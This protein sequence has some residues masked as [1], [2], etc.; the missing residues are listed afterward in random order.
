MCASG[1]SRRDDDWRKEARADFAL[2]A[3]DSAPQLIA[4]FNSFCFNVLYIMVARILFSLDSINLL[5]TLKKIGEYC[6][7]V[8]IYVLT[9][10]SYDFIND[11]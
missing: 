5:P 8:K 11:K 9:R 1:V 6:T 10:F 7:V 4:I 3:I 2:G